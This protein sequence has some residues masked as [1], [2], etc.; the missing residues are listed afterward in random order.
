M[1]K[2]S[3]VEEGER[4]NFEISQKC[5]TDLLAIENDVPTS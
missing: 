5:G 4:E 1:R 2:I 3:R